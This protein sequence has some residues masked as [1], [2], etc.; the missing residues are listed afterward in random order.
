MSREILPT[1]DE[2][3]AVKA[4][5]IIRRR[6]IVALVAFTAV[7][8]AAVAFALYLPDLYQANATVLI[9][10]PLGDTLR[11]GATDNLESRLYTI[12]STILSRDR[13][14]ELIE[15]FNLYPELRAKGSFDEVL[16]QA[17]EDIGWKPNG[18]EQV[19]GRSKTVTFTLTY[20]GDDRRTVAEVTNAVAGFYASYNGQMRAAEAEN[21]SDYYKSQLDSARA[22]AS[23]AQ[24]KLNTFVAANQSQ[25]PQSASVGAATYARLSDQM[26]AVRSE[27]TRITLLRDRVQEDLEADQQALAASGQAEAATATPGFEPTPQLRDM[28]EELAKAKDL[29]ASLER[30]GLTDV[31][32]DLR[33]AKA[34]VA[35]LDEAVKAKQSEELAAHKARE[36]AAKRA[37]G[38]DGAAK[39]TVARLMPRSQRSIVEYNE[40]LAALEQQQERIQ[41][42]MDRLLQRFDGAPAVQTQYATLQRDYEA[43]KEAHDQALRRYEEA[44]QNQQVEASGQAERFTILEAAI[45]PEGPSAPNRPRLLIMGLLLALAAAAAAIVAREQFDTSFHSVDEIREFTSIPVIATIP[46]IGKAPRRGYARLALGT[47]SAV[48]AIVLVGTLSAY[49]ANGNEALVRLLNRAG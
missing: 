29:V 43:A 6:L 49:V 42:E 15:R 23:D 44:K 8:A 26:T 38:P 47:V 10:R 25:L 32:P 36:E 9:E 46:Q 5:G 1:N 30:K 11:P 48:A 3:T 34:S 21:M 4:L 22:R 20:T 2:S 18:P 27:R 45:P 14:T 37:V 35:R 33:D 40:Q 13:L 28:R 12:Q 31:H 19:S 7:M 24:V 41:A 17:R 39:A 16:T